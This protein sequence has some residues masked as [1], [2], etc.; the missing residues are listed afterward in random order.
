MTLNSPGC[1]KGPAV[2]RLVY[3]ATNNRHKVQEVQA[4]MGH[5]NL[6]FGAAQD[7]APGIDWN[8]T[9][10]TFA[11]NARIKA[12]A[13]KQFTDLAVL[14]DDSGLSVDAL[15]GAP[16]IYSSRYSGIGATDTAN[17]DRLLLEMNGIPPIDRSAHFV[18]SLCF[19]DE[20]NVETTV[21]AFC[22]GT[23]LTVPKGT[24]GFGYDPIFLLPSGK[25]MSELSREE[26]MRISH[27]GNA[28]KLLEKRFTER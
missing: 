16:G 19:I 11:E 2:K 14:A 3:I 9:G 23:I 1:A 18:C 4:A 17:V 26:K 27:R 10:L 8:E 21:E 20:G 6:T 25:T 28:L 24:G 12:L 15:G 5:L 22:G 7:I 13:L